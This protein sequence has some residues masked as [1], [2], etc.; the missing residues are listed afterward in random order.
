[1]G[2]SVSWEIKHKFVVLYS[3]LRECCLFQEASARRNIVVLQRFNLKNKGGNNH[4]LQCQ[5]KAQ[6][7]NSKDIRFK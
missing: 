7:Q 2:L 1:M 3:K 4:N 5:Q 6:P